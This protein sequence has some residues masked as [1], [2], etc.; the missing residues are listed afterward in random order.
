MINKLAK[1]QK[2]WA[3]KLIL[4]L[5][6]L[7]F[8][9]LF[10]VS[11]YLSNASNNRAVIRVDNVEILQS[12]FSYLAQNELAM[13]SALLGDGQELTDEMRVAVIYGLSQK[14]L[15]DSIL[16]RTADKYN[17]VFN[18]LFIQSLIVNDP[19]F[20]D[21]SGNFS[22]E[23]FR[24][25]LAKSGLSEAEYVKAVKR[26]LVNRFLIQGQVLNINVPQVLLDAEAK[27]D[28]KRRTF[29]YV[30]IKPSEMVIDRSIT[31]EEINQYYED[32]SSNYMEPERRDLTVLYVPMQNI[33]DN[34]KVSDEDINFY[35]QEN[36]ADYETPETRQVLQM[37]F[38]EEEK[39]NSA[40][41]ELQNG[42]D[43]Y[44]VANE[45]ARQSKEDTDLGFAAQDELLP[46]IASEVYAIEKGQYTKPVKVGDAWQ[47][48]KVEDIKE[49]S[50]TSF[51][52]AA[53]EIEKILKDERLYDESYEVLASMEDKLA[54]GATLETLSQELN[55]ALKKVSGF[56]EDKTALS[57]Y[58]DINDLVLTT[59]FTD[60]GFSYALGETSQVIE[61]DKGLFA[62]R[63]DAI[64][65][66]HPKPLDK[67]RDDIV[68]LWS[69]NEKS[70][71]AQEKL[72]DV[73][74][75]LE[76]GDDMSSVG[77]RYSLD[78]YTSRP[79]T[80]NETFDKVGYDDI[81][82]MFAEPL[83][84]PRQI[85]IGDDYIVAV[86]IEDYDNS[87]E[88]SKEETDLIKRNVL[89]SVTK[90]F[91]D[92]LLKSYADEYKIRVKYKLM[93]LTDL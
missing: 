7:S 11:G 27:V 85:Q 34:I 86:A 32:F 28:N 75:D 58:Q 92:A 41:T 79:L 52:V 26:N 90:D 65:E 3:A 88:L 37:M 14:L 49:G 93:G 23:M 13:V 45:F 42:K 83:N 4:T 46:E 35:Y 44:D 18:P 10:G 16:D 17:V 77:E 22:K 15:N 38:D 12:Q 66:T 20:K 21:S 9:S 84:T 73:M 56:A 29:K 55:V 30:N 54:A 76:N 5:T 50:K 82:S 31:D 81:K 68:N 91:A 71:I 2:G 61:T 51:E 69:D 40:Y 87:V 57:D 8:M 67:V 72:N 25:L 1:A 6:A 89:Q 64:N 62:L 24:E 78:V 70:A 80:R 39:A 74:H 48:M 36:K 63:V 60:A 59:E 53:S 33:Y 43:F 47:I 19:T